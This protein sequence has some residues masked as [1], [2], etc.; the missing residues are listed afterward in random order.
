MQITFIWW[1]VFKHPMF[2]VVPSNTNCKMLISL[3]TLDY[4]SGVFNKPGTQL[5]AA[6]KSQVMVHWWLLPL[7][8]IVIFQTKNAIITH[9]HLIKNLSRSAKK[10]CKGIFGS[11]LQPAKVIIREILYMPF[12]KKKQFFMRYCSKRWY[13]WLEKE[14]SDT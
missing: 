3:S 12:W 5:G 8:K 10:S 2:A 1:Y 4:A 6:H 13:N 9:V 7:W 14:C 11:I